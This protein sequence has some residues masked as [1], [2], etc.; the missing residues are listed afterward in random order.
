ML[1]AR[2]A[3]PPDPYGLSPCGQDLHLPV[4]TLAGARVDRIPT[5]VASTF[6]ARMPDAAWTGDIDLAVGAITDSDEL[7]GVALLSPP[8]AEWAKAL[9]AVTPARRRL[10][11]RADLLL[12]LIDGAANRALL[13]IACALETDATPAQG[14]CRTLGLSPRIV[15]SHQDADVIE[16]PIRPRRKPPYKPALGRDGPDRR[17]LAR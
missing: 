12:V 17:G 5:D 7:V 16:I 3:P 9:V 13:G 15:H 2:P 6:V 4:L 14:L 10:G 11:L 8:H 1:T